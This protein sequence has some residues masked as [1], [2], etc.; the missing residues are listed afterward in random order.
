MKAFANMYLVELSPLEKG[1]VGGFKTL[2]YLFRS[3]FS[4]Q[5]SKQYG[6]WNAFPAPYQLVEIPRLISSGSHYILA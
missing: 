6:Y 5:S 4:I 2:T 1:G 3:F